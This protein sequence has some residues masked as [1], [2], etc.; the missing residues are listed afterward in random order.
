MAELLLRLFHA[1]KCPFEKGH[2]PASKFCAQGKVL[3]RHVSGCT[4]TKCR[5]ELCRHARFAL[6]HYRSCRHK[7]LCPCCDTVDKELL[8]RRQQA[9]ETARYLRK[10]LSCISN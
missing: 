10:F 7:A 9:E 6:E 4:N 8:R 1:N 2:C 5:Y 3:W